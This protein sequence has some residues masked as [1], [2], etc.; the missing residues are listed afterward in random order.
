MWKFVS[1][2]LSVA[3]KIRKL[4]EVTVFSSLKQKNFLDLSQLIGWP[5]CLKIIFLTV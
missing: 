1:I 3:K 2:S 4:L 5:L